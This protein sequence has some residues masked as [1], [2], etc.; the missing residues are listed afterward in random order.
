MF[1]FF[2][3][4]FT[5]PME[6]FGCAVCFDEDKVKKNI[7]LYREYAIGSVPNYWY[8]ETVMNEWNALICK[9]CNELPNDSQDFSKIQLLKLRMNF[10][11]LLIKDSYLNAKENTDINAHL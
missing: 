9:Y 5:V 7:E 6:Y 1:K 11:R 3:F 4:L 8:N 10:A 2:K